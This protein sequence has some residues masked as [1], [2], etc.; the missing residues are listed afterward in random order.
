LGVLK[1]G[2]DGKGA[3]FKDLNG[4]A[5]K[6]NSIIQDSRIAIVVTVSPGTNVARNLS[7]NGLIGPTTSGITPGASGFINKSGG[8]QVLYLTSGDPGTLNSALSSTNRDA[9]LTSSDVFSHEMGHIFARWFGGDSNTS[10]VLMEN[11]TRR[12][13]GEPTTTGHDEGHDVPQ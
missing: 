5:T 3:D 7:T 4:A 13:N 6:L 8:D 10:S 1:G 2:P 12:L 11:D 9:P